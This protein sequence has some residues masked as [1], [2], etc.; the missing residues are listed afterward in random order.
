MPKPSPFRL[1][2]LLAALLGWACN[3]NRE[4]EKSPAPTPVLSAP[5]IAGLIVPPMP[6]HSLRDPAADSVIF[7]LSDGTPVLQAH[8]DTAREL[9]KSLSP[10]GSFLPGDAVPDPG[11]PHYNTM[12]SFSDSE[13]TGD[14]SDSRLVCRYA[15]AEA[16]IVS[17]VLSGS[18]RRLSRG[19]LSE[20]TLL[21]KWG[22]LPFRPGRTQYGLYPDGEGRAV[23]KPVDLRYDIDVRYNGPIQIPGKFRNDT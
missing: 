21:T 15:I 14:L 17:A 23:W 3:R 6:P 20:D 10:E 16:L 1:V 22:C 13:S 7:R 8:I 2:V 11:D 5:M 19:G 12:E 4:T 9:L 18:G